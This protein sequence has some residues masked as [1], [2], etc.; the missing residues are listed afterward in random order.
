MSNREDA[1]PPDR[2]SVSVYSGRTS[3]GPPSVPY[4]EVYTDDASPF[5]EGSTRTP[6]SSSHDTPVKHTALKNDSKYGFAVWSE[7]DINHEGFAFMCHNE[8]RF[9]GVWK[10]TKLDHFVKEEKK[11]LNNI[12]KK[13]KKYTSI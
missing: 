8:M 5:D 9:Q 2:R 12:L 13:G 7:T 1:L 4:S 6:P 10:S 3:S 11:Q